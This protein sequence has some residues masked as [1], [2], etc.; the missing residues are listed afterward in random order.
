MADRFYETRESVQRVPG[1]VVRDRV[2]ADPES[3]ARPYAVVERVI[4]WVTGL[5]LALLGIRVVLSLLGANQVNPFASLIYGLT[6]PL[7][8][9]FFGLF[10]YTMQY[11]VVR[12]EIETLVAML[13]YAL[14]G[15]GLARLAG[16][17]RIR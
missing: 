7:V 13:V 17:G 12:F 3:P 10:G 14:I 4:L 2:V 8:A 6:A 15:Y 5:I 11:G 1:G 9:P 16:L